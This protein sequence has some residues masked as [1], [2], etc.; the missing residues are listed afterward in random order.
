MMVIRTKPTRRCRCWAYL[1]ED[2]KYRTQCQREH[3]HDGN[4]IVIV[5]T[6][7]WVQNERKRRKAR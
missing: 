6:T 7:S 5:S 3:G 2:R 1:E 4:H